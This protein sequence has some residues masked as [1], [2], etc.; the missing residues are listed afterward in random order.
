MASSAISKGK[1]AEES[2]VEQKV[3]DKNRIALRRTLIGRFVRSLIVAFWVMFIAF[4]LLRFSPGDPIRLALGTEA[5]EETV[6]AM[7]AKY[8]LDQSFFAQFYDYFTGFFRGDLG[9]SFFSEREVTEVL[10]MHL[11]VT[12]MIIL[13]SMG[14]AVIISIPI[15]LSVALSRTC[16][17]YLFFSV[18]QLLF[19]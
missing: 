10:R 14:A 15:A 8:G 13:L 7:K 4:S 16:S 5:T 9:T 18:P 19:H 6:A 11:P 17:R 1:P 12:L 3:P 2:S